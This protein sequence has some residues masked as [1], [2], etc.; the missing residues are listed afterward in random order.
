MI[1]SSEEVWALDDGHHDRVGDHTAHDSCTD[2]A[3]A[4]DLH[5][6]GAIL[7]YELTELYLPPRICYEFCYA[8]EILQC[9]ALLLPGARP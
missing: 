9:S 6:A 2:P 3:D 5:A 7:G 4:H 1:H 8:T